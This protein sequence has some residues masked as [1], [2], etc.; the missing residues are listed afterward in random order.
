MFGCRRKLHFVIVQILFCEKWFHGFFALFF[1]FE[2]PIYIID[3]FRSS[4]KRKI[5]LNSASHELLNCWITILLSLAFVGWLTAISTID[6]VAT[7]H[8]SWDKNFVCRF[9]QLLIFMVFAVYAIPQRRIMEFE[10][11]SS[12]LRAKKTSQQKN[13]RDKMMLYKYLV[14]YTT[15]LP[16][17]KKPICFS[18]YT[19]L[20][21]K[22]YFML[23]S[24]NL[25][26]S[27]PLQISKLFLFCLWAIVRQ[28]RLL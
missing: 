24:C 6:C 23:M 12:Q 7:C 11:S 1:G 27:N 8:K 14:Y 2:N 16:R 21:Q 10:A 3:P 13:C 4:S 15:L 28:L 25:N 17:E 20:E 22:L 5:D 26:N 9:S 18:N 19:C